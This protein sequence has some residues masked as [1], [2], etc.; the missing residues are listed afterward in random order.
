MRIRSISLYPVRIR[1]KKP[2]VISLGP[3]THAENVF[4]RM[5]SEDGHTGWGECSPFRTIHGETMETCVSVGKEL[6]G[7]ILQEQPPTPE[8]LLSC[9]DRIFHGNT[10]IKSAYDMAFFDL[11]A[12]KAELPLYRFLGASDK[13]LL[14]TDYT[15]SLGSIEEM[16]HDARSII[17]E[18]FQIIKVKL[19]GVPE[20]DIARVKR[21]REVVGNSLP[22][23]I[24]A[25]QGWDLP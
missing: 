4:V 11:L 24:D 6:A 9:M 23:R 22:I 19:G 18:G 7:K 21:I 25:N 16:E 3:L 10:S 13:R 14:Q 12:R 15:V 1:L 8:L 20:E 2:F 17:A 5:D